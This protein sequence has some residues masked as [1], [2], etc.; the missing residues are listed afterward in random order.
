M[1]SVGEIYF[2]A[3][4]ALITIPQ[5]RGGIQSTRNRPASTFTTAS[6]GARAGKSISGKRK[7]TL[8]WQQLWYE[9]FAQI[10]AYD[11]GHNG[12]GPFVIHDPASTN[13][14]TVNQS[15]ATSLTNDTDGF[16]LAASGYNAY[17]NFTRSAASGWATSTSGQVWTVNEGIVADAQVNGALG[18]HAH[19][20]IANLSTNLDL[21]A[22]D[23]DVTVFF[24]IPQMPTGPSAAAIFDFRFKWLSTSRH[25]AGR[26]T[27]DAAGAMVHLMRRVGPSG[28]ISQNSVN[29]TP[30]LDITHWYGM[31][32][33]CIGTAIKSAFWDA[34]TS[35]YTAP[36]AWGVEFTDSDLVA[37]A[38]TQISLLTVPSN[39][40][41]VMSA[42]SP[43]LWRFDDLISRYTGVFC[44]ITSSSALVERGPRAL[45]WTF[46][47]LALEVPQITIDSP[48]PTWPGIPVIAGQAIYFN[49]RVR[50]GGTD[51]IVTLTPKLEWRDATGVVST[52]SGTPVVTAS[53]AWANLAV[54]ATPPAS[55]LYVLVKIDATSGIGVNSLIYLDK[56]QLER[57]SAATSWRPGTGVFPVQVM[58]LNEQWPWQA[59]DYRESPV[60]VLQEVGP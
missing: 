3:P 53:G 19:R 5:P 54:T 10:Q 25:Y 58:S 42:A 23:Q 31:R 39:V 8:N 33:Q 15:G 26:V 45:L 50:G 44:T 55:A 43:F 47:Q 34:T 16:T 12:D 37:S 35:G 9:T 21:G 24:Q 14:L 4:G 1:T 49:C 6:G 38:G 48:T 40:T 60:M 27:V 7:F 32:V 2:G 13:W 22:T 59:G 18:L 51:P 29:A 17:D 46:N 41:N 30:T 56:F 20:A 36:T 57:G 11:Q 28:N 52:T